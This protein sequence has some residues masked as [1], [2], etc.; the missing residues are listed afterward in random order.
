MPMIALAR[1]A[2]ADVSMFPTPPKDLLYGVA[3]FSLFG[4]CTMLA[5]HLQIF[6]DG[7]DYPTRSKIAIS[8]ITM[9]LTCV[10]TLLF[11]L[12]YK[13]YDSARSLLASRGVLRA[14]DDEMA[15]LMG[16]VDDGAPPAM[17][18]IREEEMH[19]LHDD[20]TPD[21][22]H[23]L[24]NAVHYRNDLLL[25]MYFVGSG[26]F[27]A[28]IAVGQLDRQCSIC[29]AAGLWLLSVRD[30]L[31]RSR[32]IPD[33]VHPTLTAQVHK[34]SN[35]IEAG[36]LFCLAGAL[37]FGAYQSTHTHETTDNF[38]HIITLIACIASP[39]LIWISPSHHHHLVTF[40]TSVPMAAF[41]ALAGIYAMSPMEPFLRQ[42]HDTPGALQ[43]LMM[44]SLMFPSI[45]LSVLYAFR[46]GFGVALC[47]GASTWLTAREV[48][49]P[50]RNAVP[51]PWPILA[52]GAAAMSLPCILL[53]YLL[54]YRQVHIV[55]QITTERYRTALSVV[56]EA[57]AATAPVVAP[58]LPTPI[59]HD[60]AK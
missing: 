4:T 9:L 25:N 39:F 54:Y 23:I 3:F 27:F 2:L 59:R 49:L 42:L 43:Y 21:A 56:Q 38:M 31:S 55:S 36:L 33:C 40:E 47:C 34:R 16:V 17:Y 44:T 7:V 41:M 6:N 37:T 13:L 46:K 35:L 12:L 29:F 51:T 60:A 14:S 8:S 5:N 22:V 28:L 32:K 1:S 11:W 10:W 45:M 57:H 24:T 18:S 26:V 48:I 20:R 15:V 52:T 58:P 50:P 19:Q 53:L 30:C